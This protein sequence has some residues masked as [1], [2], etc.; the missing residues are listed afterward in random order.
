ML[1]V[2]IV[3]ANSV[4]FE[5]KNDEK[6]IGSFT[7]TL[8]ALKEEHLHYTSKLELRGTYMFLKYHYIYKEDAFFDKKGLLRFKVEEFDDGKQ[9][10]VS[11]KREGNWLVFSNGKT[12]D[13]RE[14]DI[15]PFDV[16]DIY[17]KT[18]KTIHTLKTFD[19]L[20]GDLL[21]HTYKTISAKKDNNQTLY[22]IEKEDN[23]TNDKEI[24]VIDKNGK[25]IKMKNELFE[26]IR[27]LR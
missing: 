12:V 25:I 18:D 26:A 6:V 10:M 15:T 2:N 22:I 21:T 13:L 4:F 8:D 1:I 14:I 19:S 9:K 24:I 17:V 5:L 20:S 23:V 16:S 7:C 11:A 3:Y 27:V